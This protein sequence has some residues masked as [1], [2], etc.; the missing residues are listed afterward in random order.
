MKYCWDYVDDMMEYRLSLG[1]SLQPMKYY[2]LDFSRYL[3]NEYPDCENITKDM[4]MPWCVKRETEQPA[5]Y[6]RRISALRQFILYLYGIGVCSYVMPMDF[7]PKVN[8]YVPY[9]FSDKELADIFE[10]ADKRKDLHPDSFPDRIVSVIY[11]L[12]YFCGLR[13]NEGREL[14]TCDLDLVNKTIF[15]RKNKSHKERLIPIPDDVAAMMRD[16]VTDLNRHMPGSEYLFPSPRGIPYKAGWLREHFLSLWDDVK[17]KNDTSRVR[18]YDLR[19]RWATAVMM[20][21]LNNG[22]DLFTVLPYMSSYMGH[23]SFEN[24]AYYIHLLP[25]NLLNSHS[26]D[27]DRFIDLLP[28][29]KD[30]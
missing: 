4:L 13:P 19:H 22:D 16:Y 12:I 15:I 1:Y 5:G 3:K 24:T 23:Q 2:L 21:L 18:V 20:K 28:E 10:C 8:R 7:L 9:I 11:R 29:V 30:E 14:K 6:L 25:E 17:E 27:W 26:V